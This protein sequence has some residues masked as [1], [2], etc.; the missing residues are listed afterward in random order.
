MNPARTV[1]N[2]V[3]TYNYY[4][5]GTYGYGNMSGQRNL[6]FSAGFKW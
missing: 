2:G 5:W 6:V 3:A 4:G 1:I